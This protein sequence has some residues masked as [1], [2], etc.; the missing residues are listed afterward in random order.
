MAALVLE[1]YGA[2]CILSLI[3][4]L[5]WAAVAKSRPELDEDEFHELEKLA[6]SEPSGCALPNEDPIVQ[7]L[8]QPA[9]ARPGKRTRRAIQRRPHLFHARGPRTT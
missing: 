3:A 2:L 8:S 9:P 7:I 4:F 5:V 1:A 6:N